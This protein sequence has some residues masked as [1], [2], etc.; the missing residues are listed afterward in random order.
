MKIIAIL[1]KY[2]SFQ[3]IPLYVV[4]ILIPLAI[5]GRA[6][7]TEIKWG[8]YLVLFM[9][10]RMLMNNVNNSFA[11]VRLTTTIKAIRL[12]SVVAGISCLNLFF[13]G[14]DQPFYMSMYSILPYVLICF[15]YK[16]C[17]RTPKAYEY[18]VAYSL[19]LL[20]LGFYRY[21]RQEA[22]LDVIGR[23]QSSSNAFYFVLMPLPCVLLI[24]KNWIK[25]LALVLVTIVCIMS[26]KRTALVVVSVIVFMMLYQSVKT[27][28][29]MFFLIVITLVL[30]IYKYGGMMFERIDT[31]M[32][33][34]ESIKDDGGSGRIDIYHNFLTQ[35]IHDIF[36]LP[37]FI[38]GK[39]YR[40]FSRSQNYNLETVHNDYL[41]FTYAYG[42]PG[43]IFMIWLLFRLVKNLKVFNNDDY[44][45]K[46]A[47]WCFL[48]LFVV[49]SMTGGIFSFI[50]TSIP[51]YVFIAL[52]EYRIQH[53]TGY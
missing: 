30:G 27:N 8:T 33:R 19:V 9:L 15:L 52:A 36:S 14:V 3:L 7:G 46:N 23:E 24:K 22:V 11:F 51:L 49:Y 29:K 42:I 18:L 39:G 1:N 53:D 26:L 45:F 20:V 44:S 16:E 43:L 13:T 4:S 6:V 50:F 10:A 40:A 12:F 41:E 38:I 17:K 21:F 47:Y 48:L 5:Y 28:K 34:L 37:G 35:D 32:F 31:I 25:V 2:V